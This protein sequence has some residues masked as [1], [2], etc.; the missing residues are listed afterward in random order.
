MK[1]RVPPQRPSN[2]L[3]LLFVAVI[4]KHKKLVGAMLVASICWL[5][6]RQGGC[7]GNPPLLLTILALFGPML[8]SFWLGNRATRGIKTA[9]IGGG[10]ESH[11]KSPLS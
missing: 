3:Q 6:F 4:N 1:L 10:Q 7:Q 8:A 2:K 11:Q 5:L 9:G